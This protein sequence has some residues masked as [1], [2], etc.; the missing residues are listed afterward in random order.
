VRDRPELPVAATCL[1]GALLVAGSGPVTAREEQAALPVAT[2]VPCPMV[3]ETAF[4]AHEPGTHGEV[5]PVNEWATTRCRDVSIRSLEIRAQR[6]VETLEI[7]LRVTTFTE[8]GRDKLVDILFEPRSGDRAL[9]EAWIRKINAEED[10]PA[11][12]RTTLKV[13][14]TALAGEGS[15]RLRAAV[16][17][18]DN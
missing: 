4:T 18:R 8:P 6:K 14:V 12:E 10:K 9:G 2:E 16:H 17:V 13:P 7:G 1:A 3:L 15:L 11:R 5:V